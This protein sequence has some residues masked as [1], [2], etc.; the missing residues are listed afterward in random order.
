M[1]LSAVSPPALMGRLRGSRQRVNIL[2]TRVIGERAHP[3]RFVTVRPTGG[4][5]RYPPLV[6]V[7]PPPA[8]CFAICVSSSAAVVPRALF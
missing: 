5:G 4:T 6:L 8:A 2:P 1:V 7:V 3:Y